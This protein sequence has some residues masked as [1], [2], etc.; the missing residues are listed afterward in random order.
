MMMAYLK[1]TGQGR[2]IPVVWL[3]A[4]GATAVTAIVGSALFIIVGGLEGHAEEVFE[5]VVML[6]AAAVITHVWRR[7]QNLRR[8]TQRQAERALQRRRVG[9]SIFAA[10]FVSVL[11]EGLEIILFLL[12]GAEAGAV[13]L[14]VGALVGLALAV[15]AG[16]LFYQTNRMSDAILFF[17]VLGAILIV[18]AAGLLGR[19]IHEFQEAGLLPTIVE[20][21]WDYSSAPIIGER[22]GLGSFLKSVVGY[23]TNPSLL[24]F[25][26][27]SAYLTVALWFFDIRQFTV[28]LGKRLRQALA[29]A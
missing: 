19:G 10:A 27:W 23:D 3:A 11:I 18:L 29:P 22:A 9:W 5:G 14:V 8:E 4:L 13:N 21:L 2:L 26:G 17:Y 15:L 28:M 6:L 24:Q 7:F 20:H 25:L 12:A 1:R 16:W